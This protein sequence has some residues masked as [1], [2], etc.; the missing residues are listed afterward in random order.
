MRRLRR[1]LGIALALAVVC[2]AVHA[3]LAYHPAPLFSQRRTHG[4]ITVFMREEIPPGIV[5]LLDRVRELL[6]TS[7][8]DEEGLHHDV[9]I[10]N[11]YSLIRFLMLRDVHFGANL[12]NGITFI[13]D[14]DVE[15]DI[16]RC[17]PLGPYDRRR[18]TL[19]ESIAHEVTHALIRRRV[20]WWANRRLPSWIKEGYCEYVAQGAVIDDAMGLSLLKRGG[21][22]TPGL[23]QFRN[24]LMMEYLI[25]ERGLSI[26]EILADPP[27]FE[28][29]EA[30]VIE[31]LRNDEAGFLGRAR[32]R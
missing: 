9:Y 31:L 10:F 24:R 29:V 11:D 7:E 16:A 6:S 19:S 25:N 4:N 15:C 8:L 26:E 28:A 32:A 30:G 12:P 18:R 27:E 23:P 21:A 17:R 13:S 2:G 5:P 3:L 1:A 20:G 22:T 14:A